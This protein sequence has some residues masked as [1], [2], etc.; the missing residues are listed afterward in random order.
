MPQDYE[1]PNKSAVINTTDATARSF[2]QHNLLPYTDYSFQMDAFTSKGN[3]PK[4][5]AF[6][7]RTEQEGT[8]NLS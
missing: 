6:I 3:G 8:K 7:I 1:A 2:V 4:C 5:T